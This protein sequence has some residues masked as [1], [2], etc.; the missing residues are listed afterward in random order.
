MENFA[1]WFC[2]N[3]RLNFTI[4]AQINPSDAQYYFGRHET[5]MRLQKQ[6]RHAFI[7]P[8]VPKMMIYGPYGSGKTQTLFY[9]HYYLEHEVQTI[10]G[11]KPHLVYVPVE[12]QEKSKASNLHMQLM[13]ALGKE[14][15]S[16]WVRKLFET[17]TNLDAALS[18]VTSDPNVA[19]AL[20][21]LRAPGEA[22]F[23]AWRWLT[24]QGLTAKDLSQLGLT[25]DL[26]MLGSKDMA[27]ALVAIG[28]LARKVNEYLIF[29]IDEMESLRSVRAGD[30]AESLHWYIRNLAEKKNSF[31][32]FLIG[33]KADV[34]DDA[35]DILR[36]EDIKN[37]ISNQ[38][39]VDIPNL[40]AIADV[41][42][43]MKELLK[44]LTDEAKVKARIA[45]KGLDTELDVF[46]FEP[47]AFEQLADYSTQDITRA[48]PRNIINA[49]NECAIQAWDENKSLID[50]SIV[51]A[52]APLVFQ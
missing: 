35:P 2:L 41:T 24:C 5:K 49:I 28:H 22:S 45:E 1:N 37:R 52:V 38:N 36:N 7:D 33:F 51:D 20:R 31:V 25:A 43:F 9:L 29:L 48:L 50:Q 30:A 23:S 8:G 40:P 34:L 19:I 47:V 11:A 14:V 10:E 6:L 17:S 4:D 26:S 3:H 39:F 12:M 46:P 15:V 32:G 21:E 18:E 27:H 44:N 42:V 13:Q 16:G